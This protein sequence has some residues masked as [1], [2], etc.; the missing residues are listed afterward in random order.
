MP[1]KQQEMLTALRSPPFCSAGSILLDCKRQ[2]RS[3]PSHGI[4]K[5]Q[6][7]LPPET[8]KKRRDKMV[9]KHMKAG[10]DYEYGTVNI[11]TS[12]YDM[13][14]VEHY[15]QYIVK[16]CN[17]LNIKVHE[18][19]AM[20]TK[21]HEVM[22]MQDKSTK[23]YVD[24]VLTTHERIVQISGLSSTL[25]PVLLEVLHM[26]Q[27]EGVHLSVKEHTETDFQVRFKIQSELQE[28]MAKMS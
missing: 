24:A 1:S 8:V 12:G 22:F 21:T 11:C 10:T 4:G 17:H 27:P 3:K 20:P 18:S 19:Y 2:H 25:A 13:T 5:Y 28:L 15:A 7:L 9:D 26:N 14:L 16:L 23:M 6:H